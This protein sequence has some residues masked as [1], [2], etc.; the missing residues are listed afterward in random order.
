MPVSTQ[1]LPKYAGCAYRTHAPPCER[2]WLLNADNLLEGLEDQRG[3]TIEHFFLETVTFTW[4]WVHRTWWCSWTLFT[5]DSF[6]RDGA[7]VG[8]CILAAC[9]YRRW[10]LEVFLLIYL[11]A[12]AMWR[13]LTLFLKLFKFLRL[14]SDTAHLYSASRNRSFLYAAELFVSIS[15][16]LTLGECCKWIILFISY[17]GLLLFSE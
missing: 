3:P 17:F 13:W 15:R 14:V 1:C 10:F 6:L 16:L 8:I 4:A 7:W 11:Q 9:V 5:N 2:C 12:L